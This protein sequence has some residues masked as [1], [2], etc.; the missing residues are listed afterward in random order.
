MSNCMHSSATLKSAPRMGFCF[1]HAAY[2]TK[3]A[4][5]TAL[6]AISMAEAE[7]SNKDL[8]SQTHFGL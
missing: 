4:E 3:P 2:S 1:P 8:G 7:Q 6:E 5:C